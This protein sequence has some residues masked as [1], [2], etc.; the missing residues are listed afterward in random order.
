[1]VDFMANDMKPLEVIVHPPSAAQGRLLC[2]PMV[3]A[4]AEEGDVGI[5]ARHAPLGTLTTLTALTA[6][7]S[8]LN[9]QFGV[10]SS[11]TNA[12]P[13]PKPFCGGKLNSHGAASFGRKD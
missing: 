8:Q 7:T 2:K 11:V 9:R 3:I 10:C 4:P 6:S 5:A 12:A 1:M 13:R